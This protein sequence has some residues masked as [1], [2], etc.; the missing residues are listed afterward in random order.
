MFLFLIY[1]FILS[2]FW[3]FLELEMEFVKLEHYR[4]YYYI[5]N[6]QLADSPW[7]TVSLQYTD[8]IFNACIRTKYQYR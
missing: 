4:G 5:I 1:L 7:F 3:I 6:H 8:N 2:D